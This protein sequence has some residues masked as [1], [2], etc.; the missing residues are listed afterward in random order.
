MGERVT[1]VDHKKHNS[2]TLLTADSRVNHND[3][4]TVC[5]SKTTVRPEE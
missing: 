4:K 2:A 3:A 5:R 1:K